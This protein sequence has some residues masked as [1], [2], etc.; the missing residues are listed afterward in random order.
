M[1][2]W[3]IYIAIILTAFAFLFR[4]MGRMLKS[5]ASMDPNVFM[6]TC[7]ARAVVMAAKQGAALDYSAES[8]KSVESLL[9]TFHET[10]LSG[11][12]TDREVQNNALY[13]GAYIGEVLRKKFGGAWARDSAVAGPG[14]YPLTSGGGESYPVG[15]C[16]KRILNGAEDNVWTKF[17]IIISDLSPVE[18]V[19][20]VSGAPPIL[21]IAV[22]ADGHFTADDA[23]CELDQLIGMLSRLSEQKGMVWYYRQIGSGEPPPIAMQIMQEVAKARLSI[24]LSSKSDYSDSI[25]PGGRLKPAPRN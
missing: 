1:I 4:H 5:T 21:K 14:T 11:Q 6:A 8:V 7:S 19:N 2:Q 16:G 22:Y 12:M 17:Q 9:G 20:S 13:F 3:I 23:A 10:R 18:N 25:G 15:W 24:R